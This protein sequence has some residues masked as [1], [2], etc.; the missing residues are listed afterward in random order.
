MQYAL[1]IP[2]ENTLATKAIWQA[3]ITAHR[4]LAELKGLC[5]GL[6]TDSM[7]LHILALLE[8]KESTSI[9][10]IITPD[11][12]W[13]TEAQSSFDAPASKYLHNYLAALKLGFNDVRESGWLRL[14]SLLRVHRE[15]EQK[16]TGFRSKA[17]STIVNSETVVHALPQQ[18]EVIEQLMIELI[19]F[20]HAEN[21]LD[22]LLRMAIAHYHFAMIM[23]F[24]DGNDHMGRILNLL[25]LQRE[26]LLDLPV[27]YFSRYINATRSQYYRLL[28][29]TR[30]QHNW[31]DWCVYMLKG[32]A[33]TAVSEIKLLKKLTQL[34]DN[35]QQRMQ[36]E[37]PK[38]YSPALVHT[39]FHYPYTKIE[40]V[41]QELGITRI[42]AAKY[43]KL[44]TDKGFVEKQKHGRNNYYLNRE[45]FALI[46]ADYYSV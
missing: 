28:Q 46:S 37:L 14:S 35:T 27:F 2:Q 8:A 40:L 43:L 30:E 3:L 22:A 32:I 29:H 5:A 42:T 15:I 44:L 31:E 19:A 25:I 10:L 11:D 9:K 4:Y 41:E 1:E 34:M 6:P 17:I 12:D 26:G 16:K 13:F 24:E 39:I 7:L 18:A 21:G 23:P 36:N 20:I 45:L 33:L 38:I